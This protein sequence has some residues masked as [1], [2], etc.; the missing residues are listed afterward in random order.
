MNILVTGSNGQLGKQFKEVSRL[1]KRNKFLFVNRYE[2]DISETGVVESVIKSDKID[3]I[4]NCACFTDVDDAENNVDAAMEANA[5]GVKN[6]A[7]ASA[8]TNVFLIHFSTDY[9]FDGENVKPY[10][11]ADKPNPKTVYGK[12][13][14]EGEKEFMLS[15]KRGLII[16]TSWLYSH[17][18]KNFVKTILEKGR[19]RENLKVIYDQVGSPTNA[20]DLANAT[21]EILPKAV[22][23][24]DKIEVYNYSNEGVAS[25][26]D[27]AVAIA[28]IKKLPCTIEPVLSEEFQTVAKRPNF[29]L[30]DKSKIKNDFQIKIPYWRYSLE[31][32]LKKAK[33]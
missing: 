3:C 26:Y 32:F 33:Q 31:E 12:S 5:L 17:F 18:G 21:L 29:S 19:K 16:R 20:Y 15:T 23:S 7:L 6:L 27:I 14:L 4:I 13:K 10:T 2:L 22:K 1:Y 9:L 8:K 28:D 11:E 30:L 25:W 24:F